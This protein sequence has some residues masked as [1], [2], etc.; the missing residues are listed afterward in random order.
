MTRCFAHTTK[1]L[2]DEKP[3]CHPWKALMRMTTCV[4]LWLVL[5]SSLLIWPLPS[6][7]A[8]TNSAPLPVRHLPVRSSARVTSAIGSRLLWRYLIG[9]FVDSTT[10]VANGVAYV[11]SD[12]GLYA[13]NTSDGTLLWR[14]PL[15]NYIISEPAVV[16]G[17]VY[18]GD[19][20][21]IFYALKASDWHPILAL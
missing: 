1:I 4:A 17:V 9:N 7:L 12:Y 8:S 20:N 3:S 11:G 21:G 15:G 18:F 6:V 14:Y 16:N 19:G 10:E 5:L 13:L 2:F